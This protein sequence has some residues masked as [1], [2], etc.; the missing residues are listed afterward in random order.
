MWGDKSGIGVEQERAEIA[1]PGALG[2]GGGAWERAEG[3]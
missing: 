3:N 2:M 1:L